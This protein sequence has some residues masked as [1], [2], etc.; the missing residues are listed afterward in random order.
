MLNQYTS[1]TAAQW[2]GYFPHAI[3]DEVQKAPVLIE[4]IKSVYDQFP[5]SSYVLTG[6]SQLILLNKVRESL[7]G[8]CSIFEIFPLTIP[9][10][11]SKH[12][13]DEVRLSVLQ[14]VLQTGKIPEI[15]PSFSMDPAYSERE[16][17]FQYYIKNGG[18]PVLTK[19]KMD[20]DERYEWLTNY[21]RTYLERDVRDLADF[22][23]LEP[24]VRIQRMTALMTGIS[25]VWEPFL[26]NLFLCRSF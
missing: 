10:I 13:E 20:D 12:W 24:F 5:D 17:V 16:R 18:Y 3:L 19:N 11:M 21:I 25:E 15:L 23:S 8:R 14:K 26:I 2:N 9:E 22:R 6:S 7:A 4:S 1:L